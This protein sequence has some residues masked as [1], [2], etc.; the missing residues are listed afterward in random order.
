MKDNIIIKA[1]IEGKTVEDHAWMIANL[2]RVVAEKF[3]MTAS[4]VSELVHE[5]IDHPTTR[6][7]RVRMN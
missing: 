2:M 5:E 6:L 4:E 1:E 3:N 7:K